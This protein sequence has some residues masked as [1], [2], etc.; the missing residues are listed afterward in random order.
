MLFVHILYAC[1]AWYGC[2][3]CARVFAVLKMYNL[4]LSLSAVDL[5]L[6]DV[7]NI[8]FRHT[9]CGSRH[10]PITINR[11]NKKVRK[12]KRTN[13]LNYQSIYFHFNACVYVNL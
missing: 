6:V 2:C 10:K 12:K 11:G 7:L 3:H 9:V 5:F 1:F 8:S 4:S 13:T